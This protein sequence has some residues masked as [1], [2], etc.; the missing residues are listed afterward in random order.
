MRPPAPAARPEL[1]GLRVLVVDDN[2]H[3]ATVIAE[4]LQSMSFEVQGPFR[5]RGAGQPCS[6][7]AARAQ[8]DLV[9]LDWQMPGMDGL[10]LRAAHWRAESAPFAALRHGHRL[11]P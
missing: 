7:Q 10:E 3:A 8:P 5:C 2:A 9:V 1:R 6:R 4:M 11:W